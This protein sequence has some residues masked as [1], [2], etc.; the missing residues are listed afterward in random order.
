M[1]VASLLNRRGMII[2]LSSPS[3]AGK[4]TL[5]RMLRDNDPGLVLSISV[6][7]RAPRPGEI[8]GTDYYFIDDKEYHHRVARGELLEQARVFN[9]YYGTPRTP[10]MENLKN[11]IDVLFDID[12]QGTQQLA[13]SLPKDILRIF[14]LPPSR[15]I[16][17]QRLLNR[18][19][20]SAEVIAHRMSTVD[21]E[22]SHFN[23]YDYVVVN[24]TLEDAYNEIVNIIAT[25]R[26]R[27]HRRPELHAFA[28][29]L[30]SAD[31]VND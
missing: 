16:L 11:G 31:F 22:I 17:H 9:H 20:D 21:Q 3:G 19:Q 27:L 25:E 10:V 15:D 28:Q 8:E 13:I 12:W 6:T 1:T 29:S 30:L 4:S 24:N 7:T 23:E 14:I 18:S 26:L 5:V 2:V